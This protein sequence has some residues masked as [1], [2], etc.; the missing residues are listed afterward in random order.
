[1]LNTINVANGL[2]KYGGALIILKFFSP[3]V[4]AFFTWQIC[5][6]TVAIL[7]L[8]VSVWR[9]LPGDK[10]RPQFDLKLL[11]RIWKFSLSLN[12]ISFIGLAIHQMDKV[13]VSHYFS[14][15]VLGYY[16]VATM[17]SNGF[18]TLVTPIF[19]TYFPRLS[20]L[21]GTQG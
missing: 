18:N 14:L 2:V 12:L 10:T 19:M 13:F 6:S 3:T 1:M 21:V 9:N 7:C 20:T 8:V 11:E 15:E 4:D 5:V 16:N 17:V